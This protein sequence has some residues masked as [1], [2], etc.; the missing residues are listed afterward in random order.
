MLGDYQEQLGKPFEHEARLKDL[1]VK[2]A[3]LNALLDLDKGE[4]QVAPPADADIGPEGDNPSSPSKPPTWQG[5]NPRRWQAYRS[6]EGEE[7]VAV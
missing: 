2:Q 7:G 5:R 1:L 6:P 3:Q 4:R